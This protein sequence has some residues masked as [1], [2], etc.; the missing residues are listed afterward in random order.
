MGFAWFVARRYLTARRKQAFISLISG[1]SILG[2]GVGVMALIIA[3]AIMTGVQT[4]LRDRIVG[5]SAHVY[6]YKSSSE[7]FTDLDAEIKKL[8]VPGVI[9]VSPA[10]AGV[11]VVKAAG[12]E[13][14]PI[15]LKG[16]DPAREPLVTD[17]VRATRSGSFDAL[18][19]PTD[20]GRPGIVL[21]AD[22]ATSLGV[23]LG[24]TVE[25]VVPE[26]T[27][28]P[29]G[30]VPSENVFTVVGT[31]EFGFYEVDTSEGFITMAVAKHLLHRTGPDF[32]QLRLANMDD[33]PSVRADL[34][35]RLGPPYQVEDWTEINKQ[36]YAALSLEKKAISLTIGLI[37]MVAALNIVASLVLL[38]MEKSR[39]IAILRTM[40]APAR[41]IRLIFMLQGLTIGC[42]GTGAGAVLGLV[43]C[44]VADRFRLISLPG[45]VY[46]ISYLP[47]RVQAVD[48]AVIVLSAV[49][50]CFLA[51]IYPA[52]QA[53][54]LDPAE[55]LRNQ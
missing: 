36:L 14:K 33:A 11:G 52:R 27:L 5:S 46:Q 2:V 1:V 42:V 39:D 9:G 19:H 30:M 13:P 32:I 50:V 38:V 28:T 6:V 49:G 40:G 31:V 22:L 4:D 29:F 55:A 10:I 44:V 35:R 45:D 54:R 24:D 18:A 16:V 37:I 23:T 43:V 53:G 25:V 34:Q 21:G 12:S 47:F 51:T 7:G 48:V 17:V 41:A 8:S 20:S 3:S 15:N 26:G